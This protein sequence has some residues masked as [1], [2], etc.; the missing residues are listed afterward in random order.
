ME[1]FDGIG[2]LLGGGNLSLWL[3]IGGVIAVWL[4]IKAVKTIVRLALLAVGAAL[5]LGVAP[6]AGAAIEGPASECAI[7]AVAEAAT[8]WE[9]NITKRITVENISADAACDE[10]GVGLSVGGAVVRLRSSYDLPFQTWDVTPAVV[11]PRTDLPDL[12][13]RGSE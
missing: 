3:I 4:A 9:S 11:E 5:W 2:D 12:P 7:A 8:G 1:I 6:W 10:D 13:T